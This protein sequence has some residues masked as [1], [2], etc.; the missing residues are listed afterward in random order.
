M[1]RRLTNPEP[2]FFD[3]TVSKA[4]DN[5][6]KDDQMIL[7]HDFLEQSTNWKEKKSA[8]KEHYDTV[9]EHLI[10]SDWKNYVEDLKKRCL[11]DG[12]LGDYVKSNQVLMDEIDKLEDIVKIIR[13]E[14]AIREKVEKEGIWRSVIS[15]IEKKALK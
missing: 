2:A 13:D 9:H 10:D 1:L 3:K 4:I 7:L 6:A 5:L 12:I 8:M 14:L 11:H 15:K